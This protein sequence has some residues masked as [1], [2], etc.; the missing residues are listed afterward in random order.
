M[1]IAPQLRNTAHSL[2]SDAIARSIAVPLLLLA[3]TAGAVPDKPPQEVTVTNTPNVSVTNTPN[4]SVTNTPNV[5]IV[6]ERFQFA[7]TV[8]TGCSGSVVANVPAGRNV[9]ITS[10]DAGSEDTVRPNIVVWTRQRSGGGFFTHFR[11]I[12]LDS[13]PAPFVTLFS[14]TLQMNHR[15]VPGSFTDGDLFSML[16]CIEPGVGDTNAAASFIVSGHLE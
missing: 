12:P 5:R 11:G 3:A 4:V 1:R 16:V 13:F 9:V 7:D 2:T 8:S 6:K 10:V 14:G 15:I